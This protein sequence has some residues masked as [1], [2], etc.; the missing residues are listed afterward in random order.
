MKS[1][2]FT[3]LGV[4]GAQGALLF[5]FKNQLIGNIE[6]RGVFHTPK[7][8]QWKKNFGE[9]PFRRD[10]GFCEEAQVD[11]ILGSPNC[12]HSSVFSYSRKKTLG[13][14]REDVSLNLFVNSI[15]K[16]KPKIFMLENLPKLLDMIPLDNWELLLPDYSFIVHCDSVMAWGNSQKSRKRML[17]VGVRKDCSQYRKFFERVF[18]VNNP[19]KVGELSK[20]VRKEKNYREM[21]D[22]VLAMYDSRKPIKK[23]LTVEEVR[24]LW[25]TDFKGYNKWP[26]PGTKMKSLP[27]VYKNQRDAYPM[28][29][30]PSSRQFN[31]RGKIMG[32]EEYR[33]IMGFPEEFE[34]YFENGPKRNY[35]LNKGRI[36]LTKGAVFEM[37]LWFK[38]C[39]SRALKSSR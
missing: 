15:I 23:N 17:I 2:Q 27:G 29:V 25:K 13:K 19:L 34:I 4:C 33:V 35:W 28:T 16:F 31:P 12:G 32:L 22:K 7:E 37:G 26:M 30:R 36:T 1:T 18:R 14:P 9:I 11:V 39:L 10:W 20:M 24:I 21:S 8:E 38:K 3:V 5:P 6:P